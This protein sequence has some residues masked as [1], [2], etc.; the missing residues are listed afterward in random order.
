MTANGIYYDD[1]EEVLCPGGSVMYFDN[2]GSRRR[3][4]CN[5]LVNRATGNRC[6]LG[7]TRAVSIDSFFFNRRLPKVQCL[8]ILYFWLNKVR[9]MTIAS[10]VGTTPKTVQRFLQQW[11]QVLQ[12]DLKR[13]DMKI[14]G[15]GITVEIDESK[16]GKRKDH[17]GHRVDGKVIIYA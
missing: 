12:E 11:Y 8:G 5:G 14:G 3:W 2:G 17:R 6:C 1:A 15:P 10:M 16:F 4:R 7:S 13:E 9:K